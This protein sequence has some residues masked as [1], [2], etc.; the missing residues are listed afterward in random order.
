MPSGPRPL[1]GEC[2]LV[3]L[4]PV[5]PSGCQVGAW[6]RSASR[7]VP[8]RILSGQQAYLLLLDRDLGALLRRC[9]W[10]AVQVDERPLVVSAQDLIHC[11][12]LQV[13]TGIPYLPSPGYMRTVFPQLEVGANGFRVLVQH[14]TPEDVLSVCLSRRIPVLES[15]I[16]Y[17]W[18]RTNRRGE[19]ADS[20]D[21]CRDIYFE[22]QRPTT[23]G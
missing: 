22:A 1:P 5:L 23:A 2:P 21:R 11:R 19:S 13:V 12:A 3:R 7:Q 17:C 6:I 8:L 9:N 15:R 10:I 20:P 18:P 4:L 16:E 14:S